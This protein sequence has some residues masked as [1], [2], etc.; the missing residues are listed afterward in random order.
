MLDTN[1]CVYL[2]NE[3]SE[4][5]LA[6]LEAQEPGTVCLSSITV[7]ELGYGVAKSASARNRA[8]LEEFLLPFELL[9]FDVAAAWTYGAVRARL[10]R[11][12]ALIGPLDM[13]IAAHAL[14]QGCT[15]VT[16]NVREFRRVAGLSIENWT[17]AH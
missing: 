16:N 12:G 6:R 4:R 2:I 11:K 13:Q 14:T 1:I 10:E 3:R 17:I 9:D 5:V 15:L 7:S 8:K